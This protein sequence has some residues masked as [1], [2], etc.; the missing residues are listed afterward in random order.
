MCVNK[1]K[2]TKNFGFKKK[3]KDLI[4]C[5]FKLLYAKL[6][7]SS[8][9]DNTESPSS[10]VGNPKLLLISRQT[11]ISLMSGRQ[12]KKSSSPL[13]LNINAPFGYFSFWA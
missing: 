13:P 9:F 6:S 12:Y 2:Q 8:F 7:A 1:F 4:F 11:E 3:Y 5:T 10:S